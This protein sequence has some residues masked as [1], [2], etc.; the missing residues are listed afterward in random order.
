MTA[1]ARIAHMPITDWTPLHRPI[2]YVEFAGVRTPGMAEVVGA[3]SPRKWEKVE[4]VGWSGAFLK[5]HG[6]ELSSFSV[7]VRLYTRAEWLAWHRF[8]PLVHRVPLG[9]FQKPIDVWHPLLEM[10]GIHSVVVED[11]TQATQNEDVWEIEIKLIEYRSPHVALAAARGSQATPDDP[12]EADI[13]AQRKWNESIGAEIE[14]AA[15]ARSLDPAHSIGDQ[16]WSL[17]GG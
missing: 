6:L 8:A 13:E 4:S 5:Y 10:L 12:I 11:V 3:S 1:H 9:R 16:L 7:H 14:R 17:V 15:A 2:N